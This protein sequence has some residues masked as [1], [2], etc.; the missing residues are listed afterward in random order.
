MTQPVKIFSKEELDSLKNPDNIKANTDLIIRISGE[1]F[2]WFW[3][4]YFIDAE[5]WLLVAAL[6]LIVSMW[7]SFWGYAGLSHELFH[8]KVYT[9]K[10][11]N[12]VVLLFAN[13]F[14]WTN[15]AFFKSSHTLHHAK[16]FDDNDQEAL[17]IQ[18][19][20]FSAIL[21]YVFFDYQMLW[22][23]VSYVVKNAF[24]F[25]PEGVLNNLEA[26]NA[27]RVAIWILFFNIVLQFLVFSVFQNFVVNILLFLMP[28]SAQML[29]R[30]LAQSQHIGLSEKKNDGSLL[31]SRSIRL[32][33]IIELLYAGMNYHCEHHLYPNVPYYNL[34]K[35]HAK[36]L[37]NKLEANFVNFNFLFSDFWKYIK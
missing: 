35:I 25:I 9:S 10:T 27:Q 6:F 33:W 13:A 20:S 36:I 2:L 34:P 7:H 26:K 12:K 15:G 8:G 19:W 3:I 29:N 18:A 24:G 22:N 31:N 30:M 16:T 32:P 28:F 5:V 17:S 11:V 14:T 21:R 4:I 37:D 1:I 23:R